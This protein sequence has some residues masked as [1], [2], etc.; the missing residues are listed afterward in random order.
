MDEK[1]LVIEDDPVISRF[2]EMALRTN[3]FQPLLSETGL[4]GI[5]SF[6]RDKP[7]LILLDLGLPDI[8]GIDVLKEIRRASPSIP[9]L[10]V[11]ARGKE[12]EKVKAL[13]LGADDYVT[14]PFG[15]SELLARVRAAFRHQGCDIERGAF[16]FRDLRI[17]FD[18]RLVTKKGIEIHFTPIEYQILVLFVSNQGKALTHRFIQEQIWHYPSQDDYQSLRVFVAS[19]RKKLNEENDLPY[20]VTE[21]GIGY[22]FVE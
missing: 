14:K 20:I 11:S 6:L 2:V 4:K 10:I 1:I 16:S 22:R 13:D 9:V 18:K 8:D 12:E 7:Q 15:I 21:V 17:D 3:H 5:A 19:I